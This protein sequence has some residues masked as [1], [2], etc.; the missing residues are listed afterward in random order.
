MNASSRPLRTTLIRHEPDPEGPPSHFDWMLEPLEK[1][2]SGATVTS[3]SR[4]VLTWRTQNRP[5]CLKIGDMIE[6]EPIAAHRRIWL[7]RAAGLTIELRPPLG[8]ATILRRGS[9]TMPISEAGE[10]LEFDIDWSES[11][12][13]HHLRLENSGPRGARLL[14]L[15]G[16]IEVP[17]R[18]GASPC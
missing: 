10:V 5:D 13:V 6:L 15:P 3:E 16:R 18:D 8:R 4:N 12:D 7:D 17:N 2:I 1:L 9:V 14:R 11:D